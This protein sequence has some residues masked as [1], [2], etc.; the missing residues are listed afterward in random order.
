MMIFFFPEETEH[1]MR[2]CKKGYSGQ[3]SIFIDQENYPWI[4]SI[5]K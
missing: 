3:S 1:V 4:M 2:I 5:V